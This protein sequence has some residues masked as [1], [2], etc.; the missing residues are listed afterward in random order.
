MSAQNYFIPMK[1]YAD[2][3]KIYFAFCYF[4]MRPTKNHVK[5]RI[6]FGLAGAKAYFYQKYDPNYF[7]IFPYF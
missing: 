1:R 4:D 6:I 7:H 3:I 2:D 5:N